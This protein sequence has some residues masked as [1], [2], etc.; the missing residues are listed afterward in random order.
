MIKKSLAVA[1]AVMLLLSVGLSGCR[2]LGYLLYLGAPNM[3]KTVQ[4]EF[5]GLKDQ[6]VAVVMF[7]DYNVL[8]EYPAARLELSK[9]IQVELT[10]NVKGI[11]VVEPEKVLTYQLSNI[12][13]E[14]M[15]KSRLGRV[16]DADYVLYIALVEFSTREP[17][18]LN[19]FRGRITAEASLYQSSG[20]ERSACVWS[21]HDMR[22]MYPPKT[23][24]A[25]L[26]QDD[27][28]IRYVTERLFA[29]MLAKKFYKYKVSKEP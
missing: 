17:G 19:I 27:R 3:P 9:M 8:Y 22:V 26:H 29:D 15:D 14:S 13:W 23:P 6:K 16:F 10:K 25:Q 1:V 4:A 18:S 7:A 11:E 21:D 12:D 5:D 20:P 28:Q 24:L 2:A